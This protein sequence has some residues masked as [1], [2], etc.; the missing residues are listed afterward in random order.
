MRCIIGARQLGLAVEAVVE[1]LRM[2]KGHQ[3]VSSPVAD[4]SGRPHTC[5]ED[6]VWK[7]LRDTAGKR[8]DMVLEH[9]DDRQEG[10]YEDQTAHLHLCSHS[11]GRPCADAGTEHD[12]L[13]Q[14]HI[15]R[16]LGE[17]NRSKRMLVHLFG[18]G[19]RGRR[20]EAV[21]WVLHDQ[22]MHAQAAAQLLHEGPA[23]AK[24]VSVLV[25]EY[26]EVLCQRALQKAAW[27]GVV[28]C[29]PQQAPA[30][31]AVLRERYPQELALEAPRRVGGCFRRRE[32]QLGDT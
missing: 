15:Q 2:H 24:V 4:E 22:D 12:D 19:T 7:V 13:P 20:T 9:P 5:D 21:T 14:R 30:Q 10:R 25:Q 18:S 6:V 23:G 16:L 17:L 29:W 26:D 27:E 11:D 3:L 28:V 31:A 8:A 32:E 1:R